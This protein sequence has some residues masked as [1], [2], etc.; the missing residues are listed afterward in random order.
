MGSSPLMRR[1]PPRGLDR[2]DSGGM[3]G[4]TLSKTVSFSQPSAFI[5]YDDDEED[6]YIYDAF[7]PMLW[8]GEVM[9]VLRLRSEYLSHPTM[10]TLATSGFDVMA[11]PECLLGDNEKQSWSLFSKTLEA[12]T[13]QVCMYIIA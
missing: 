8:R 2:M 4:R 1:T 11:R 10:V 6:D 7:I 5:G 12:A 9:G 13:M 3:F